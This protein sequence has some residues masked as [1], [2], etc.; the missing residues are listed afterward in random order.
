M[1][2]VPVRTNMLNMPKSA[3][4]SLDFVLLMH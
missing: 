4:N 2:G 3:Y 1:C